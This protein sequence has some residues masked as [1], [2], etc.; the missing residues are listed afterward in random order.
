MRFLWRHPKLYHL[1]GLSAPARCTQCTLSIA[2]GSLMPEK[3]VDFVGL[4]KLCRFRVPPPF[5]CS[6]LAWHP[7]PWDGTPMLFL[8]GCSCLCS[9]G[10]A[11]GRHLIL[12][13]TP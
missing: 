11:P 10:L 12:G 8:Q 2:A 1:P 5:G 4:T 9:I 3:D 6:P 7:P 13:G